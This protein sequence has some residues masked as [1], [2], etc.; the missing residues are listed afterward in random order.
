MPLCVSA[1]LH[2][3]L[4]RRGVPMPAFRSRETWRVHGSESKTQKPVSEPTL[5][6]LT[7]LLNDADSETGPRDSSITGRVFMVALE[8]SRSHDGRGLRLYYGLAVDV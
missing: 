2:I 8:K 5:K 4:Y 1:I 6:Q 3:F 7:S